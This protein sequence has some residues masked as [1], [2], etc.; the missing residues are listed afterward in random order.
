M[1]GHKPRTSRVLLLISV[2]L[3]LAFGFA[4]TQS[5]ATPSPIEEGKM[6]DMFVAG[7][8]DDSSNTSKD[9]VEEETEKEEEEDQ[10]ESDK[11]TEEEPS[12]KEP[13]PVPEEKEDDTAQEE[14]AQNS[15]YEVS[16]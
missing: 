8:M 11:P 5:S 14:T 12:A 6:P 16:P 4:V 3:C 9:S 2:L 1:P 13:T 10:P 7:D 15:T